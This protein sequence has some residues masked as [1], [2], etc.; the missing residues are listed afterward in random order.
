[1]PIVLTAPIAAL[2]GRRALISHVFIWTAF[3]TWCVRRIAGAR[4]VVEG[5]LPDGP[6]LF[7]A[8]HESFFEALDLIGRLRGPAVVMKRELQKIPVWGWATNAYGAIAVDR[9]ASSK[10]LRAIVKAG[11]AARADGRSVLIFAE[12]TRVAIG[13]QPPLKSGFAGLYRA[14]DLPV[15]PIAVQSG[16][17]W[18][19][20]GRVRPG[21]IRIRYGAPIPPGLPRGEIEAR[22]HAAI[23]ALPESERR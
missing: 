7:V 10:A 13:T 19:R 18:L 2:F 20:S 5:A 1:M 6:V 22:V 4:I 3:A 14:L 23:N 17:V 21:V 11:A 9:S 15:V 16:H 12:G 8:K